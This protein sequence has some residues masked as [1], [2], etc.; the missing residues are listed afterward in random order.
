M[1]SPVLFISGAGLQ[2]WVWDDV[3]Q[4]LGTESAV[5][6]TPRHEG[7]TLADAAVAALEFAPWPHFTVVAHSLGGTIATRMLPLAADRIDAVLGVAALFPKPGTSYAANLPIPARWVLPIA[8]RL[9]GTRPPD[10]AIRSSLGTGLDEN[11]TDRL[12]EGF[13]PEPRGLYLDK[14]VD[15]SFPSRCGYVSTS[16]DIELPASAQAA[17]AARIGAR[18][19]ASLPTA[20]LPMLEDSMALTAGIRRFLDV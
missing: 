14:T 8:L 18:W 5:A 7:A 20:H 2:T 1:T 6:E 9:T 12:V 11:T 3:R 19:T 10:S 15:T 17:S 13:E 4:S 16:A